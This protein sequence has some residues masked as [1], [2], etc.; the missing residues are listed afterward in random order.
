MMNKL[1][2]WHQEGDQG[3]NE[4][5]GYRYKLQKYIKAVVSENCS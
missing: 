1:R 5:A 3:K 4:E 2:E